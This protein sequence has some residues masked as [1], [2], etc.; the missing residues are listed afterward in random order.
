MHAGGYRVGDPDAL[1]TD[2][3]KRIAKE[4]RGFTP[5]PTRRSSGSC[6]LAKDYVKPENRAFVEKFQQ[7]MNDDM[8][9]RV[10]QSD[11]APLLPYLPEPNLFIDASVPLIDPSVKFERRRG[12][13]QR[14]R[15][16]DEQVR[17]RRTG[18]HPHEQA[19]GAR[20]QRGPQGRQGPA[21]SRH[22]GAGRH[23]EPGPGQDAGRDRRRDPGEREVR[24]GQR[25]VRGRRHRRRRPV[26]H[27]RRHADQP[28]PLPRRDHSPPTS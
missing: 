26:R 16:V 2:V 7:A 8:D 3:E 10:R 20:A 19:A 22:R 11:S 5:S 17:R 25:G 27:R 18:R 23:A 14:P 4:Q 13:V 24:Q 6:S 15:Q 12:R 1:V 9:A 21:R 28:Q